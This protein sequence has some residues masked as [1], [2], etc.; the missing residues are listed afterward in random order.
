MALRPFFI[1]S[2]TPSAISRLALH[3]T[4]YPSAINVFRPTLHALNGEGSLAET[5]GQSN[6][7]KTAYKILA[8]SKLCQIFLEPP[9]VCLLRAP[10]SLKSFLLPS[11]LSDWC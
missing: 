1:T 6:F 5:I 11:G 2:S 4:Q 3:L 10:R 8:I 9:I 7:E